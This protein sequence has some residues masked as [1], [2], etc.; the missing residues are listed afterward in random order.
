MKASIAAFCLITAVAVSAA[1]AKDK[2]DP[3]QIKAL[4][5]VKSEKAVID[6]RWRMPETNVLWVSMQPD[7]S[8]RDGFA[9]YVCMLLVEAGAPE[10]DL[11]T[12]WVYDPATFKAGGKEMGIAA[13]R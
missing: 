13:C 8:S 7:G 5:A 3:W 2:L 1:T 4:R 11:K 12:V 6:A 10:G 9:Q